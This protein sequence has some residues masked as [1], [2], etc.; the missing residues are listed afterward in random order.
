[1]NYVAVCTPIRVLKPS[2]ARWKTWMFSF[3]CGQNCGQDYINEGMHGIPAE[4]DTEKVEKQE[5]PQPFG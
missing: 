2:E 5:K 3:N 1:M 4:K